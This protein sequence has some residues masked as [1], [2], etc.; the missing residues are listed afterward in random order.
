MRAQWIAVTP[1]AA[2]S[3][4]RRPPLLREHQVQVLN[5][6]AGCAFAEIIENRG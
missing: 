6:S 1:I 3:D 2:N 4:I 5:R